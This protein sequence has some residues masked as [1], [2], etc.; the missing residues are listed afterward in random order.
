MPSPN[1]STSKVLH[2]L[3]IS[4][5]YDLGLALDGDGDR[6]GVVTECNYIDITM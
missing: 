4:K 3:V 1:P 5:K 6:I 2:D